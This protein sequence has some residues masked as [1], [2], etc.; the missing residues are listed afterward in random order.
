MESRHG[1]TKD[2]IQS[3]GPFGYVVVYLE[4]RSWKENGGLCHDLYGRIP[5]KMSSDQ[6]SFFVRVPHL[7]SNKIHDS[8]LPYSVITA[9]SGRD[10]ICRVEADETTD[11]MPSSRSKNVV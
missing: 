8:L 3:L 5:S 9:R 1:E 6:I 10:V 11:I 2:E 4:W 7:H